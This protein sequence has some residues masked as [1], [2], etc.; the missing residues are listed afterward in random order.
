MNW[1]PMEYDKDGLPVNIP[2]DRNNYYLVTLSDGDID[3]TRPE[4]Y[5]ELYSE[6]LEEGFDNEGNSCGYFQF[7][8]PCDEW[9]WEDYEDGDVVAY[10]PLP[11][12]Y[13]K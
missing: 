9:H 6:E 5:T 7:P 2:H 1:I 10:L 3:F 11:E 12:P 13:K 8:Y 4:H